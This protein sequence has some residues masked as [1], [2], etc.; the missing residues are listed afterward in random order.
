MVV[1]G[2]GGPPPPPQFSM[3]AN[4]SSLSV[5]AGSGASSTLTLTSINCH[6]STLSLSTV[7]P[8]ATD[9]TSNVTPSVTLPACG[10]TTANLS[11][12]TA[13]DTPSGSYQVTVTGQDAS[14]FQTLAI[15]VTVFAD[16]TISSSDNP[17]YVGSGPSQAGALPSYGSSSYTGTSQI[18]VMS[19]GLTGTI[20][21]DSPTIDSGTAGINP[22]YSGST[23]FPLSPGTYQTTSLSV[24]V[25]SSVTAGGYNV[26]ITARD[27]SN[28]IVHSMTVGLNI[29]ANSEFSPSSPL[30]G[31]WAGYEMR[32]ACA[33]ET[34]PVLYAIGNW[35]VPNISSD[36]CDNTW[37]AHPNGCRVAFWVGLTNKPLG[38]SGI[39]QAG[40]ESKVYCSQWQTPICN[41]SY[42]AW[43]EFWSA[44]VD[45]QIC[46]AL[47]INGYDSVTVNIINHAYYSGSGTST[48]YD[49]DISDLS[50][51][52]SCNN[53]LSFASYGKTDMGTPYYADFIVE[54]IQCCTLT[55]FSAT[56]FGCYT[57][58]GYSTTPVSCWDVYNKGWWQVDQMTNNG[59]LDVAIGDGLVGMWVGAFPWGVFPVTWKSSTGT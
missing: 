27:S 21:L 48:L 34:V 26:R 25:A 36:G 23:S 35:N 39:V 4:P 56:T 33:L 57:Y 2:G 9:F 15:P 13:N 32:G 46:S 58:I 31:V 44:D 29:C 5:I 8:F 54:R 16:F 52:K 10:N 53:T 19:K 6:A 28:T 7:N 55:Q 42:Y 45:F 24:K 41:Y 30:A 47:K 17:I 12:G 43:V 49:V 3:T 11:I 20:S 59:V 1:V 38:V 18:T 51:G 50:T 14:G 37:G 22:S 40:T